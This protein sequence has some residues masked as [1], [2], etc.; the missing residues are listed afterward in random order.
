MD[1]EFKHTVIHQNSRQVGAA[2]D[3]KSLFKNKCL[4]VR[5]IKK[6]SV[7]TRLEKLQNVQKVFV[8]YSFHPDPCYPPPVCLTFPHCAGVGQV[9]L[10]RSCYR[11]YPVE[12][13]HF[14]FLSSLS[15][16][17]NLTAEI[18]SEKAKLCSCCLS[19]C[20]VHCTTLVFPHFT[21]FPICLKMYD[22]F[23][24][25]F[26]CF[27]LRKSNRARIPFGARIRIKSLVVWRSELCRSICA[28]A[29]GG[30]CG[31]IHN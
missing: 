23:S 17:L 27:I 10:F 31:R 21:R 22:M 18:F 7:L 2:L 16:S 15:S 25:F 5:R 19:C 1:Q 20:S 30:C 6:L 29:L 13:E 11:K 3:K 26:C 24:S 8:W 9:R 28:A 12:A 14:C 4:C